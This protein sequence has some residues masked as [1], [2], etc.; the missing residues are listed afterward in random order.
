MD[1]VNFCGKKQSQV[2]CTMRGMLGHGQPKISQLRLLVVP[3]LIDGKGQGNLCHTSTSKPTVSK[4]RMTKMLDIWHR[5]GSSRLSCQT[6]SF[7]PQEK[8]G[9]KEK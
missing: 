1:F 4:R 8:M 3:D 9:V 6:S 5:G 2:N 7:L